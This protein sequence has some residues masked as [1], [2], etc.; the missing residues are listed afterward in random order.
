MVI[1]QIFGVLPPELLIVG[2]WD[3]AAL[4]ENDDALVVPLGDL[5]LEVGVPIL[6]KKVISL[7][8]LHWIWFK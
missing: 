7:A 6:E 8:L 5:E 3:E 1:F 4:E 2:A